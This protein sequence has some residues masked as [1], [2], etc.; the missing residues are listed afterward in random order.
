MSNN[1]T[2]IPNNQIN[3]ILLKLFT[4]DVINHSIKKFGIKYE[5]PCSITTVRQNKRYLVTYN[6]GQITVEQYVNN[7]K[8]G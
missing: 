7:G 1:K 6:N 4:R 5:G 3:P 8:V 2:L